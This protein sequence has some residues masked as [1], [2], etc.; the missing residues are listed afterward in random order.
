MWGG[1]N[2]YAVPP[3]LK[4]MYV[5]MYVCMHACMHACMYVCLFVLCLIVCI[6]CMLKTLLG[7]ILHLARTQT[8]HIVMEWVPEV[9]VAVE[10]MEDHL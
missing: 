7:Q 5:C 4:S 2:S 9:K 10:R 6:Y 8:A 1:D 3:T